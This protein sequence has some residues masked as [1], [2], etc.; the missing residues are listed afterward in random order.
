MMPG[1]PH[2]KKI[3]PE[4]LPNVCCQFVTLLNSYTWQHILSSKP[5]YKKCQKVSKF[6]IFRNFWF[7]K[8]I[9]NIII[10]KCPSCYKWYWKQH[11]ISVAGFQQKCCFPAT[12]FVFSGLCA[13]VHLKIKIWRKKQQLL[14]KDNIFV[15]N[16]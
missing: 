10:S 5:I 12:N 6:E 16:Q 15:E 13:F 3:C 1:Y 14:L 2:H 4:G 7:R 9:S 11:S 8:L